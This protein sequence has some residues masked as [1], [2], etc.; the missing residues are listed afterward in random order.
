MKIKQRFF[1]LL[2]LIL[3]LQVQANNLEQSQ[4]FIDHNALQ[5]QIK[6][7][8]INYVKLTHSGEI[9]IEVDQ[10]DTR[11]RLRQCSKP[12]YFFMNQARIVSGR[13][14]V[15]VRCK[16]KLPW[17]I[18][19][20]SKISLYKNVLTSRRLI[21]PGTKISAQDLIAVKREITGLYSG[22][23]ERVEQLQGYIA[24]YLIMPDTLINHTMISK[25]KL[26]KR[27]DTVTLIVDNSGINVRM[28]GQALS[29]GV[30]GQAIKV[31][32]LSSKD[33]IEGIIVGKGLV[34]IN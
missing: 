4:Q 12:L 31:K 33:V 5:S 11:H 3:C 13:V 23:Y 30:R 16:G 32:N 27:G 1:S 24:K 19:V 2:S 21:K 9:K 28:S 6:Q 34:K 7:Y 20:P 25:A 26:I 18:Y 29:S 14:A 17:L 15:G 8:L 10:I 22:Y